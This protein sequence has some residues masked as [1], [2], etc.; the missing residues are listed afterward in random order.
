MI[1]NS[2]KSILFIGFLFASFSLTA[3]ATRWKIKIESANIFSSPRFTDLNKDGIKDV[4]IGAGIENASVDNG[5]LAING[6]DGTILWKIATPSQIYTSALFQDISGDSVDDV[7]IGGRAGTFYA[8]NGATGEI[9]WQFWKGTMK[10]SRENG[11]LNFFSTQWIDDQNEDGYSDLLVTNGGDYLAG[12]NETKRA[13]ANL[14]VLSGIDGTALAKVKMPEE[15]ESYYAPHT[16]LKKK[17]EMVVFGTGGETINGSLWEV[18]L[19]KLM[20]N[21]IRKSKVIMKDSV[22]GFILNSIITDLNGDSKLDF[23]NARMNATI[24][25]VDGKNYKTLWEHSFEGYE[26]YVTP[27]FGQLVGDNKPD[28][29][30]I[31][32]KGSFPMYTSFKLLIIDG[33]TG[34]LAW[35]EDSGFNQFSP[36]ISIDLNADGTD[37]IV[38]IE[39]TLVDVQTFKIENQVKVIDLKKNT[40]YKLGSTREGLSM[41]SSPGII[42]L[43]GDGKHEIIVATSSIETENSAQFSIIECIDLEQ[44]CDTITWPG[45]LGP[46]QNGLLK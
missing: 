23:I 12:T 28:V 17:K 43:E 20:K 9:I 19:K 24:S 13:V 32:A 10:E 21:N 30:T 25:A 15:R 38:Y 7:F 3:Q 46:F 37:E 31:I 18:P 45:Y 11:I 33:E 44:S 22:K 42:D 6:K 4:I 27:S 1:S 26:C 2:F 39:N 29:F 34:E 16:Y 40:S 36:A 14:M 5:I 8:I 35:Q 41:A